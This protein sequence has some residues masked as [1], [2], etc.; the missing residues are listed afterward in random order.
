MSKELISHILSDDSEGEIETHEITLTR[1]QQNEPFMN[2]VEDILE[3][4]EE[5]D[6]EDLQYTTISTKV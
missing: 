6:Q 3:A 4:E 5:E 2:L 1:D